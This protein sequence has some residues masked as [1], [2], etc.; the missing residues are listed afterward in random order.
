MSIT[1]IQHR[2]K[3]SGTATASQV[4]LGNLWMHRAGVSRKDYFEA[5]MFERRRCGTR[6]WPLELKLNESFLYI[7]SD[8]CIKNYRQ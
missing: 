7:A 5:W 3:I 6:R 8:I 1:I 2:R 4:K